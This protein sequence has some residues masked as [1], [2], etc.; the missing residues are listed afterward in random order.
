MK[1]KFE[2]FIYNPN[3]QKK[4]PIQS[5]F[6]ELNVFENKNFGV[7]SS[8]HNTRKYPPTTFY[9]P[10]STCINLA[11]LAKLDNK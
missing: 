6:W 11:P 4:F 3:N 8:K 10:I 7:V 2:D 5:V 9:K 1:K